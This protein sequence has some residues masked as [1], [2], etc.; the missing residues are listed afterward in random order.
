MTTITTPGGD[1]IEV[2]SDEDF[3]EVYDVNRIDFRIWRPKAPLL[4]ALWHEGIVEDRKSGRA[5]ALLWQ[6]AKRYGSDVSQVSVGQMLRESFMSGAVE[7]DLNGKRTYRIQLVRLP[8]TYVNRLQSTESKAVKPDPKWVERADYLDPSTLRSFGGPPAQEPTKEAEPVAAH[9]VPEAAPASDVIEDAAAAVAR[10]LLAEVVRIV[11]KRPEPVEAGELKER[12]A[13]SLTYT[14]K[15]RRELRETGDE[16]H[17]VKEERDALRR[18]L[19]VAEANID[20]ALG[21]SRRF[22]DEEV[23][24]QMD[25]IMSAKPTS[26]K[27]SDDAI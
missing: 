21:D 10:E 14:E 17:A 18:R 12:L 7:R 19:A 24:K 13:N 8:Q 2:V 16:L 23:R 9:P 26:S 11:T 15:L 25:R 5:T 6:R 3:I 1:L 4:E 20:K 22:V 27:G